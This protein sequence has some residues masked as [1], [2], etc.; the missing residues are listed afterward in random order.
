LSSPGA[1]TLTP[2]GV[3]RTPFS[4][5]VEAPRQPAARQ[6][7]SARG[8][9]EL[10]PGRHFEHA[11][12]DLDRWKHVWVIFWFDRNAGWRPK[13]LPPRS[14]RRRGVFATR[15]PHRP[16]PLGLSVLELERV[17]GL[18]LHVKGVDLLDGTPVLDIKPY[19]AYT[20]AI[21]DSSL[22]W[23]GEPDPG[24]EV[25]LSPLASE[26]ASF[27]RERF[28]L[29]LRAPLETTLALGPEPHPYRRIRRTP[30]GLRIAIKSWRAE[31]TVEGRRITVQRIR[32][33]YRAAQLLGQDAELECHWAFVQRFG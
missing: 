32:S 5:R 20:D 31:L 2:I 28:E 27:L 23:L 25:V 33:G 15:S 30:E 10:Y 13:V 14:S 11:L 3:A 17:D 19:V 29:D 21:P 12:V 18:V 16:N 22:G 24:F 1:L 8:T 7:E 26:Q 9:I 6:A 4:E